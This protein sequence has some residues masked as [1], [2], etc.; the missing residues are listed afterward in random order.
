MVAEAASWKVLGRIQFKVETMRT[1]CVEKDA[2]ELVDSIAH[3]VAEGKRDD[4]FMI[5]SFPS[6]WMA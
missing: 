6:V 1:R 2:R 4:R 3:Q 5:K